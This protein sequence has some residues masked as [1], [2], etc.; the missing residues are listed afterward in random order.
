MLKEEGAK[1]ILLDCRET[2]NW[3][4]KFVNDKWLNMNKEVGDRKTLRCT[5]KDQITNVGRQTH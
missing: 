2:K 4:L 5:N 3:I 1:H